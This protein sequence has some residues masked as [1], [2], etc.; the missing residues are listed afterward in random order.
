M[1]YYKLH[2]EYFKTYYTTH[3]EDIK[4][5]S[6]EYYYQHKDERLQYNR[7]YFKT[8]YQLNKEKLKE[9][10]YKYKSGQSISNVKKDLTEP[11]NISP[12]ILPKENR[13]NNISVVYDEEGFILLE[14]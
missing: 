1:S 11:L 2:R 9:K 6:L 13:L 5:Q 7:E 8:Y 3:H 12:K 10:K 4:K 14:F